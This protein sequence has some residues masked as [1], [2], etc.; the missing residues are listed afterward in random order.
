MSSSPCQ[1]HLRDVYEDQFNIIT[2]VMHGSLGDMSSVRGDI[3]L[4]VRNMG[5]RELVPK[6]TVIEE[7]VI[8][9]VHTTFRRS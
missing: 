7:G 1:F 6:I 5:E 3:A 8:T 2:I 9:Q 4:P